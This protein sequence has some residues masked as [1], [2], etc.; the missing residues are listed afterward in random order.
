ML[1]TKTL[2]SVVITKTGKDT[3][4]VI[5]GTLINI[6][7]GGLFFIF[8]PRILG[9]QD[10]GI[11]STV[12]AT[13]LFIVAI[14]NFGLDTG[15]L[16]F[17][18]KGAEKADSI[19]SIAIRTYIVLG[20]ISA[21][22]GFLLSPQIAQILGQN[23]ITPYLRIGFAGSIFVLLTN[24]FVSALQA[25]QQFLKS[26][27]VNI[28]GN[29]SRLLLLIIAF[30]FFSVNLYFLTILYFFVAIISIVTGKFFL[31]F[32]FQKYEKDLTIKFY[33]YNFWVALSL[34]IAAAPYDNYFLLK[35]AGPAQ[36]GI[37]AAPYKILTFA[38]QF[39][40]NFTSILASRYATFDTK[41]KVIEFSKKSF[42]LILLFS[43]GILILGILANPLITIIFG[44]EFQESVNVFRILSVGF[45]F[46]F[47]SLIPSSIILYY[48]G[49]SSAS[50]VITLARISIFI[51]S[52]AVLVPKYQAIGGA[53][54]FTLSEIGVFVFMSSYV[55]LSLNTKK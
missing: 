43:F 38:Y 37:Y 46:F 10:F 41:E 11:F 3:G 49:K 15:I 9:P 44:R 32:Q 16:K 29:I 5:I 17:A 8:A 7:A 22:L 6:L 48:L 1:V 55:L 35:L 27:I 26:S 2:K 31:S 39:G 51:A 45:I 20:L 53:W 42:G 4:I 12:I 28:S 19:L 36:T 30:Y 18:H 54:A 21:L 34:I 50:F 13:G 25:R 33:K 52:L 47:A 40:G 24:F 23:Q 14:S